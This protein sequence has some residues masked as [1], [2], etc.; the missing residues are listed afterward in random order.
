VL[1]ASLAWA[2]G[3]I[4]SRGASLPA[5]PFLATG[6]EM[7]AG[8]AL[9]V[10]AGLARGEWAAFDPSGISAASAAA[11][12]YLVVF[13]SLI[14][15]T[16]YIWLLGVSTPSRVA[17]YAY[18][19]PVVAVLLGWALAGEALTARVIGAAAVIV[20][21]VVLI[22]RERTSS[23]PAPSAPRPET[24]PAGAETPP[25]YPLPVAPSTCA[26]SR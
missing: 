4:Y 21:A 9:L 16:S 19:N 5:S 17:T 18:V 25:S 3:S 2:T 12:G 22:T 26:Q 20:A 7:I 14:G 1:F 13:G 10:A 6:M 11:F 15:F 24:L 23:R 8:G